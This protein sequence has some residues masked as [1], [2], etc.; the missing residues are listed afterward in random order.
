MNDDTVTNHD[1]APRRAALLGL[2]PE[3][4][5]LILEALNQA[6][7]IALARRNAERRVDE[8]MAA[9]GGNND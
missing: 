7:R 4:H 6:G 1:L 2:S 3:H 5:L 9:D 8:L